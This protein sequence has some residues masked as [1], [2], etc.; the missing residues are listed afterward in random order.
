MLSDGAVTDSALLP[1]SALQEHP[2]TMSAESLLQSLASARGSAAGHPIT[3]SGGSVM[4]SG[5]TDQQL[6][7]QQTAQ[8]TQSGHSLGPDHLVMALERSSA[9]MTLHLSIYA[10]AILSLC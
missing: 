2:V 4:S 5:I 6:P 8:N 9:G 7:S 10:S 3:F 1:E